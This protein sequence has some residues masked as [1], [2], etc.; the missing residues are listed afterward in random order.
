M[1]FESE[2]EDI[3]DTF[4]P[5]K[6]GSRKYIFVPINDKEDKFQAVGGSHWALLLYVVKGEYFIY[7]DSSSGVISSSYDIAM[8]VY[9]VAHE[10]T[11][12]VDKKTLR[13]VHYKNSPKQANNYDCGMYTILLTESLAKWLAVDKKPLEDKPEEFEDLKPSFVTKKRKELYELVND[14][15]VK[16]G[17]EKGI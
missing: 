15:A 9:S 13:I 12:P 6:F 17:K 2:L 4:E 8:K 1:F 14:L 16:K 11:E 10:T 7:F 5:L 3:L